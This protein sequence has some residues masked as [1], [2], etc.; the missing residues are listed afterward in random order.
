MGLDNFS[1]NF[2]NLTKFLN[3]FACISLFN[4]F[5][6]IL[7]IIIVD[8]FGLIT[9][10]WGSQ[11]YITMIETLILCLLLLLFTLIEMKTARSIIRDYNKIDGQDPVKVEESDDEEALER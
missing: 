1:A 11:L 4:I 5:F 8:I 9:L 7:P 6:C 10:S 3:Y 2:S